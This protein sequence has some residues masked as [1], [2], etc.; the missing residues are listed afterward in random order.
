MFCTSDFKW[1]V[2]LCVVMPMASKC[3]FLLYALVEGQ[4]REEGGE[5][6]G[7]VFIV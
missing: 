4:G 1:L 5:G 3:W 7:W 6:E 2:L